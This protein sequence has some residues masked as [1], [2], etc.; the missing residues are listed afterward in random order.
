ML[1]LG[2]SQDHESQL[3]II[4]ALTRKFN[5]HPDLDLAEIAEQCPFNYTGADFY[6]LCSDA[7]LKAMIRTISEID[8]KIGNFWYIYIYLKRVVIIIIYIMY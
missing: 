3:H 8:K 6:A 7:I 4:K 2:V 1:Y 5:L